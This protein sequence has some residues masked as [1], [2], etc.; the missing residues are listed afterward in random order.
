[1]FYASDGW[2]ESAVTISVPLGK[3]RPSGQQDFPPAAKFAVPGLRYRSIV[4]IVQ[5]V[6][7]TDPNVHDFHL[8]PFRQYVKGQGGRPP[9]RVVD[10][11]YSSDAMMEEYEALQR[12]PREPGCKFERII[13]ALQFWSDATQLANFGSAK[14]WPIYMY[15]GNQPKWARSRSDM[16][17]CHD[18]AY[19]PSLPS[20][21]QDFVVDQRGF[22]AD[23]KL[24][25]HC[26][27]ELFH[28]VWKLLLDKKFIRAYKHGIL[29]EFPD[30][31]IRRVYL[32]IITYSADYPEKVIIATIRNL[33]ICLCPRCLI[34]WHQIRKLGL[35]A[36]TKL[37]IMK[38]RT[39][40]GGLRSL[41]VKARSFIYER[42]QGV[43]STSV[44]AILR[45]ESLVP[46]ISAFSSALGEFG[47]DFF[48]MLCIDILHE[49]ELGVWKALLQ[50]LIRMLHAVGENKVVELDRRY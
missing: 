30:R 6:I 49:F 35:K 1:P 18:I 23:P 37:R 29:I 28:G 11:I 19:I 27:R 44:D 13:F 8:H 12:S 17:A 36:D 43:A 9:S 7:R 24:E 33:G 5:R 39:D 15:F 32:R 22:P 46:T 2:A 47:F 14:L 31:I 10:D 42:R 40:A 4:D 3:P 25:T 41:V 50:H 21:F 16:H 38:R 26:R 45:A 20:T 48:L 34:V